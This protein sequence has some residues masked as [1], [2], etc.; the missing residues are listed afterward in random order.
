MPR[1]HSLCTTALIVMALL[2]G[3]IPAAAQ[4]TTFT[5]QGKFTDGANPA[6]GNYDFEFKLFSLPTGGVPAGTTVA[7]NNVLVTAGLFNVQL[8]FGAGAFP[9]PDRYLEIAVKPAGGPTFT[10]LSPR[11]LVSATPYAIKSLNAAT[12]DGLSAACVNCV[13][14]SQIASV[15]GSVVTGA[16]PVASVPTGSGNYIQNTTTQQATSDFNISGTGTANIV[17]ALTQYNLGGSRILSNAGTGN[18]LAGTGAGAALT[19]GTRNTFLGSSA[20][21]SDVI[22]SDNTF[23]GF[24]A[25]KVNIG[26]SFSGNGKNNTYVGSRAG[27]ANMGGG[28]NAYFGSS[29]GV[30]STGVSNAYFGSFAGARDTSGL[31]N[32]LLGAFADVGAGNL[33]NATAIGSNAQVDASNALVLGSI[34]GVNG[35]TSDTNVG[36][37]TTA[38][39][40][41]LHV[42]GTTGLIGNVG[43]GTTAPSAKLSVI[44]TGDG[45]NVLH[46]G[47]E[48]A[49]V[50]KQ[51]GSGASTAL[52]LTGADASNNNKNFVI[53]T[54]GNVGIGTQGPL[55]RLHVFGDLRIGVFGTNGC[56]KNNNGGTII[57]NCASDARFKRGITP[58]T[59]V[60][61]R[62]ARLQPV[63]YFWRAAEF[64]ERNFGAAREM[65][66]IAQEV[67]QV[68]PELVTTDAQGFK[69]VDY[70][71]LPLL[72]IQAVKELKA[73][74]EALRVRLLKLELALS[75]R[76]RHKRR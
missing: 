75:A 54:T 49:W 18:L 44:A 76:R 70:S 53:N 73:E 17:N 27:A 6:N 19:T 34:N 63:H 21:Q 69:A 11:Q 64:P 42:V 72:T 50:F 9:G 57:G 38:P 1:H 20:G 22:G 39:T 55:D 26:S 3:S 8:N 52:E 10:V 4:T 31:S 66:L 58:V 67:E 46:L 40:A 24:E 68:L 45:A 33:I 35:S 41:R 74:N 61:T 25:G 7:L 2:A 65:G 60:L 23:I 47:I 32:T 36:I 56:L 62:L 15:S 71:K 5:Y 14:S 30:Q 16:I 59:P 29:A 43:I 13:T 28:F 48:R 37:G 12:A 51:F